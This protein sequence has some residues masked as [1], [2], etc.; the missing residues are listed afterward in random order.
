M[1]KQEEKNLTAEL[2]EMLD[3]N[4]NYKSSY[5][6]TPMFF[7]DIAIPKIIAILKAKNIAFNLPVSRSKKFNY[8]KGCGQYS[9]CKE[10]QV[11]QKKKK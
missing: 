7:S 2:R 11:C 1:T 10:E 6:G 4:S 5:T 3:D 9:V 8:C